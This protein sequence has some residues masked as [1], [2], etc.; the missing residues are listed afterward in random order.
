MIPIL[1]SENVLEV[2]MNKMLD[3]DQT[4][5]TAAHRTICLFTVSDDFIFAVFFVYIFLNS[6]ITEVV[7]LTLFG[8]SNIAL[9]SPYPA[10]AIL[11]DETL[12]YRILV[13]MNN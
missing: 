8:L 12:I 7:K 1:A 4:I 9:G 5:H 3:K 13:L 11:K 6:P 10:E 2:I